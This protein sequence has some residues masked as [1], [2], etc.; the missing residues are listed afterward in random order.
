MGIYRSNG[1]RRMFVNVVFSDAILV[2]PFGVMKYF[3]Y[4]VSFSTL[5]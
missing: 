3:V 1:F 2:H 4:L 5:E